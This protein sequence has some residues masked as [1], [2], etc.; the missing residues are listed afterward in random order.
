MRI[1]KSSS[2]LL[3]CTL[4]FSCASLSKKG[5]SSFSDSSSPYVEDETVA[6][7][8]KPQA[9]TKKVVVREEKVKVI[10]SEPDKSTFKF[11]V[12]IGSFRIIENAKNYKTQLKEEGFQPTILENENGLY[13]V[14]VKGINEEL[15]ARNEIAQIRSKFNNHNDVWLLISK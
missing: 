2:I 9:E 11:Y 8:P 15:T 5:T 6:P 3:L 12:I 4:I 14:S 7:K 1:I 10:E 13:R